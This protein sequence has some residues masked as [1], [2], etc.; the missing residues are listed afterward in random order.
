MAEQGRSLPRHVQKEFDENALD[1]VDWSMAFTR[2]MQIPWSVTSW[3]GCA[4]TY[5][6]CRFR[7][8]LVT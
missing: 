5:R 6:A 3:H 8:M 2:T 1:V 7:K 4:V